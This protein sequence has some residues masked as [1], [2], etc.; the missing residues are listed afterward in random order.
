VLPDLGHPRT[1]TAADSEAFSAQRG[2]PENGREGTRHREF[3]SKID[4]NQH[5]ARHILRRLR[6]MR[7]LSGA[8][9]SRQIVHRIAKESGDE[10]RRG[11]DGK[12]KAGLALGLDPPNRF[13]HARSQ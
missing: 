1:R 10:G 5:R 6:A 4:A 9:P 12:P 13:F 8:Q 11:H 7:D 2:E 3:W